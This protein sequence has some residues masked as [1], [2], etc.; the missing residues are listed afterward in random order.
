MFCRMKQGM[1]AV[2]A[3]SASNPAV[4]SSHLFHRPGMRFP[5]AVGDNS[6]GGK[7]RQL[8]VCAGGRV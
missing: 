7:R 6:I 1:F 8:R 3:E 4:R 5:P 2:A